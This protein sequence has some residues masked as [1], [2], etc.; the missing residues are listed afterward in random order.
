ML[1]PS[2]GIAHAALATQSDTWKVSSVDCGVHGKA[3]RVDGNHNDIVMRPMES[4][5][6]RFDGEEVIVFS[7][8][9]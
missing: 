4:E 2:P 7:S 3:A 1:M 9:R 5:W 8:T 6:G